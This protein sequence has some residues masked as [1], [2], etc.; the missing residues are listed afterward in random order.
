MSNRYC[1]VIFWKC[2]NAVTEHMVSH[3]RISIRSGC[4]FSK[5]LPIRSGS[6]SILRNWTGLSWFGLRNLTVRPS[7][8]LTL[9][10]S[11]LCHWSIPE[12]AGVTFS[13][14]DSA[15]IPKFLNPT[16]VQNP[17]TIIDQTVLYPCFYLRNDRKD[18]CCCRNWKVTPGVGFGFS[19]IFDSGSERKTLNPAGVDSG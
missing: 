14:S 16:P 1:L 9:I 4:W 2:Q 17:A 19:Q 10:R 18:S 8:V 15:S 11:R 12:V 6:D 5:I 3:G 13:D 7:Q